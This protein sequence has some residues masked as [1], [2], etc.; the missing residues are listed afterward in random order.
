MDNKRS[1]SGKKP[2]TATVTKHW[3]E[4][5]RNVWRQSHLYFREILKWNWPQHVTNTL[6]GWF[7]YS[8]QKISRKIA[9]INFVLI[10]FSCELEFSVGSSS[11]SSS[12]FHRFVITTVDDSNLCLKYR[13][14]LWLFVICLH[15]F[16]FSCLSLME[17]IWHV[18]ARARERAW[19]FIVSISFFLLFLSFEIEEIVNAH[20]R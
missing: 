15:F 12:F 4:H 20:S 10:A 1:I 8:L 17:S 5:I 6:C 18:C 7:I 14:G 16:H 11:S 2:Q 3:H 19:N 9:V 13:I